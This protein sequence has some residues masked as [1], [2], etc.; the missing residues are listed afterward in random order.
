MIRLLQVLSIAAIV[1]IGFFLFKKYL[2]RVNMKIIEGDEKEIRNQELSEV[3]KELET[4]GEKNVLSEEEKD[5]GQVAQ[6]APKV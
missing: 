5:L 4:S 3:V 1:L 6:P 2:N